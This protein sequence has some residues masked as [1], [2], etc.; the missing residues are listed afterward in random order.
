V[1]LEENK[2]GL[3]SHRNFSLGGSDKEKQILR[4]EKTDITEYACPYERKIKKINVPQSEDFISQQRCY[5][6]TKI[7]YKPTANF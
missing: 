2:Y 7:L 4:K 5:V 3:T 1:T 6:P